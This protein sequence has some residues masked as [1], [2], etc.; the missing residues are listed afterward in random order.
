[1]LRLVGK[2]LVQL[3]MVLLF[4][5]IMTFTLM[6]LAP[7]DPVLSILQA[8]KLNVTRA[9]EAKLREEFGFDQPLYVQ[10]GKWMQG[11]FR[12]DLGHSY[13]TGEPVW[14]EMMKRLP[15]TL[16]LTAGALVVMLFI[17]FPLGILGARYPN[18]WPDQISRVLA[19]IGASVPSFWLGLFLIYFFAFRFQLLPSTGR[20]T[21]FHMILPSL[22][23]GFS[24]AAVYARLLRAGLLDSLSQ[25]YIRA[26]RA[27]GVPERR[28][29]WRHALRGALL[30]IITVFGTSIGHLIGGS[31]VVEML[32][33]WP[34]LGSMAIEAIFGRD[35]P[36]IQGYV[37]L[38]GVFVVGMNLLVD[39][40]Y[41][42]VDPR[43]RFRKEDS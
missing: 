22:T 4:L 39:L 11:L 12:L 19:L 34:G 42:L 41:R 16:Q 29:L 25:E 27:R 14:E 3:L 36:V 30:P 17:S 5:S 40:S 28:I 8:D 37:L 6:K 33:S 20:D 18:K 35:Y 24:L 23:L 13:L 21:W 43:I 7:G 10:Y 32:F 31:V 1:M 38:T 2:R 9:D 15:I 26:A